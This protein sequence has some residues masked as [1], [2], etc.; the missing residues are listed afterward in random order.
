[1]VRPRS[2]LRSPARRIAAGGDPRPGP[3][4]GCRG[5]RSGPSGRDGRRAAR[6]A[7]V[8]GMTAFVIR[9]LTTLE[10]CRQVVE[11]EKR[12]WGYTDAEDVVPSPVLI[13]TIKRGGILLG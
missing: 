7:S 10:E 9:P 4:S 6:R 2:R 8:G 12:V 5:A 3:R 1:T 13:V 11:L